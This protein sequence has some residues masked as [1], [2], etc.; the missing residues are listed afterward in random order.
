MVQGGRDRILDWQNSGGDGEWGTAVRFAHLTG[1]RGM[2]EKH[3]PLCFWY[4]V[5]SC[6]CNP[7]LIKECINLHPNTCFLIL[8]VREHQIL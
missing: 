3:L 8:I 1:D 6:L 4:F 7:A 5:K 2:Q